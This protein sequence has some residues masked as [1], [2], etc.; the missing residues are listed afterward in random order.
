MTIRINPTLNFESLHAQFSEQKKIR[1]E[2]FFTSQTAEYIADNLQHTTP[3]HMVHSDAK[4]LPVR[5]NPEQLA[6]LSTAQKDEID[7]K[8]Q[9]LAAEH[10]QYKYKFYPIIDS[11]KDGTLA[12][13]SMLYQM[14]SFVNG[15]EF[16]RFARQLTD[17]SSLVKMDP[18]ASLYESGDFLTMHDDSNYQR[19]AGDHSSRRFA[20]VFGFTKHWSPNW[21]GQTAFYTSADA[22]ESISWNPGY[23]VLTVFEVPVQHC[24][25]YVT[26]FATNGRYSITG[27][28]RDDPTIS[29]PDLG[30]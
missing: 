22:V 7:T 17:V 29:R 24:V 14:A 9:Q 1:I 8:L 28:L 21:G 3:W 4:G 2:N 5:Y 26:P 13:D 11:I 10:Y 25:N 12:I 19:Q 6:T 15:T 20:V 18:Q 30:D 27:W 23:N 16:M